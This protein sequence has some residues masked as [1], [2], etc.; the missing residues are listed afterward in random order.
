MPKLTDR[1]A[2]STNINEDLLIHVVDT[3]GTDTSFKATLSQLYAIF[4]KNTGV[5]SAG[6]VARWT[7][8]N[9]LGIGVLQDNGD[10]VAIGAAATAAGEKRLY[11]DII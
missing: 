6:Y 8:A 9:E 5:G 3:T 1:A 11:I 7:A 2:I 10:N 4:P